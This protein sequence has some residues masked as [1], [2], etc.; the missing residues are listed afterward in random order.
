MASRQFP[1]TDSF[2]IEGDS[3]TAQMIFTV[4]L[5]AASGQSIEVGYTTADGTAISSVDY[6]GGSGLVTFAPGITEQTIIVEIIGD[7][8]PEATESFNVTLINPLN[9]TLADDTGEGAILDNEIPSSTPPVNNIQFI[10]PLFTVNESDGFAVIT[11]A[12]PAGDIVAIAIASSYDGTATNGLDYEKSRVLLVFGVGELQKTYHI[13]IIDDALVEPVETVKL[14]LRAPTGSPLEGSLTKAVLQIR[15][16]DSKPAISIN[17]VSTVEGDAGTVDF[18][19]TVSLSF[20]AFQ[21]VQVKYTTA[22][23]T[24]IAGSDYEAIT[25]VLTIPAGSLSKTITIT[26]R[27]D[28]LY[29]HD[30]T[31]FRE[32]EQSR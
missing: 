5:S 27:G 31:F 18:I 6:V 23:G 17:D 25:N 4:S 2:V 8:D 9:A 19:F 13:Q 30:E 7:S 20:A 16:N 11:V 14:D 28:V 1:V 10:G 12:R 32:S 21:D 22:D 26:V 3:G 24:A 29:E 15:D